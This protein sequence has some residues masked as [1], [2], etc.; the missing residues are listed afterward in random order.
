MQGII[1]DN[2]IRIMFSLFTDYYSK[3]K[4]NYNLLV[5]IKTNNKLGKTNLYSPFMFIDDRTFE[6]FL[7]QIERF[8]KYCNTLERFKNFK[9]LYFVIL[10]LPKNIELTL[11]SPIEGIHDYL[12]TSMQKGDWEL[13]L[14]KYDFLHITYFKT[15]TSRTWIEYEIHLF[16]SRTQE[17]YHIF[18]VRSESDNKFSFL[19]STNKHFF[20]FYI[21]SK[22]CCFTEKHL[23]TD[24]K[25]LSLLLK[26]GLL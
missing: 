10:Q 2:L 17:T 9:E 11:S 25:L 7:T 23:K 3:A 14:I 22:Q 15:R 21:F 5:C 26:K 13:M 4:F 20:L 19:R 8:L 6:L 1:S 16:D 12:P 24:N 18:D